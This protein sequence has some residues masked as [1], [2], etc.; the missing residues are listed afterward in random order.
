MEP[1]PAPS[2]PA[3]TQSTPQPQAPTSVNI[4]FLYYLCYNIKIYSVFWRPAPNLDIRT[5][6]SIL[7]SKECDLLMPVSKTRNR[8]KNHKRHTQQTPKEKQRTKVDKDVRDSYAYIPG[9]SVAIAIAQQNK[10]LR[11]H[12][13]DPRGFYELF[14]QIKSDPAVG[15]IERYGG[16]LQ[17]SGTLHP[18]DAVK[19]AYT[20][21]T[22]RTVEYWKR[23]AQTYLITAPLLDEI[24]QERGEIKCSPQD[25]ILPFKT[26]FLDLG[27]IAGTN[28]HEGIFIRQ[29]EDNT[30]IDFAFVNGELITCIT[31]GEDAR[32]KMPDDPEKCHLGN[33]DYVSFVLTSLLKAMVLDRKLQ[34]HFVDE[35]NFSH[36]H[37]EWRTYIVRPAEGIDDYIIPQWQR[38][39]NGHVTYQYHTAVA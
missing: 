39:E 22:Y 36:N 10:A 1:Q 31:L 16:L 4:D 7:L 6:L 18:K 32:V 25:F 15:T 20:M 23:I 9:D 38:M 29:H 12:L 27:V 3:P 13:R 14:E 11:E 24:F 33:L 2:N 5:Q 26:F 28:Q 21:I 35:D 17:Q 37:N 30:Q 34:S 19:L 8:G